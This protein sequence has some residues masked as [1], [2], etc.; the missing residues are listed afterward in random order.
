VVV[1]AYKSARSLPDLVRRLEPVL[2]T[3]ASEYELILVD[4]GSSDGT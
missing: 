4:D 3:S 2:E 1:P